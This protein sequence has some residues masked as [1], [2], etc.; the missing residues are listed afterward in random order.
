V[1]GY[2]DD[3]METRGVDS[4]EYWCFEWSVFHVT[5]KWMFIDAD[6]AMD[7]DFW[8]SNFG[9]R[10]EKIIDEK[11]KEMKKIEA[12][13]DNDWYSWTYKTNIPHE[14]FNVYEDGDKYCRGI[15]FDIKDL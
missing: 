8:Y 11:I 9:D 14:T 12:Q 6:A 13:W 7:F 5:K 15:V 4:D 2:S 10:A 3:N 1:F